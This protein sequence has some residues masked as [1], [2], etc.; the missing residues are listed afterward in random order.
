MTILKLG[1]K[2]RAP[3]RLLRRRQYCNGGHREWVKPDWKHSP[4]EGVF[5]GVRTYANGVVNWGSPG[6]DGDPPVFI[7]DKWLKVALICTDPRQKPI[8]VMYDECE[9]IS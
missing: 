7:A 2:V 8:P 5:V 6:Y 1:D 4:V 9:V 3:V